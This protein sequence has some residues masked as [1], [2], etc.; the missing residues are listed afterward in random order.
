VF[1]Q[2]FLSFSINDIVVHPFVKT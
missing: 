2:R 1:Y